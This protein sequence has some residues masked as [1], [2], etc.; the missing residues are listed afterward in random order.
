MKRKRIFS[1]ILCAA[2]LIALLSGC[3]AGTSA[4]TPDVSENPDTHSADLL[5][6]EIPASEYERGLWYGFLPDE[7]ADADPDTTAVTW[8]QYCAMLGRM[9]SAYDNSKL[10]EWEEMTADAPDSEMKR[11]GAAVALYFA[12]KTMDLLCFNSSFAW[13][14]DGD[15]TLRDALVSAVRLYE[16][17][18]E[19]AFETAEKLLAAVMETEQAQALAAEAD[20]RKQEILNSQTTIVKS[21]EYVQAETYT[22]TAHYVS[23]KG[24]DS[25]KTFL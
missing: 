11:D 20:A 16:S 18:E 14:T 24:D 10:P 13:N 23:N 3:G 25:L 17:V 6:K 15:L 7:L 21:N 4:D 9:I 2:M 19:V 1:F 12:G 8:K 5:G 22:G